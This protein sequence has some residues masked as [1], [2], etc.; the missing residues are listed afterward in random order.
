MKKVER[1]YIEITGIK[2]AEF[3]SHGEKVNNWNLRQVFFEKPKESFLKNQKEL[4][5]KGI[6]TNRSFIVKKDIYSMI[7][8]LASI[9]DG[10]Y[11]KQSLIDSTS[12][13]KK[14][15]ARKNA[16]NKDK[17]EGNAIILSLSKT[18]LT[19]Y[20]SIFKRA[21]TSFEYWSR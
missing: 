9:A 21:K 5:N 4:I 15:T 14:I 20:E 6:K 1:Y 16:Y 3:L 2:T 11:H 13:K 12:I 7:T 8:R 18:K 17:Q 10:L 19:G